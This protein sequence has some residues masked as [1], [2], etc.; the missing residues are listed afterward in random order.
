VVELVSWLCGGVMMWRCGLIRGESGVVGW[1]ACAID[2]TRSTDTHTQ[3]KTH[4]DTQNQTYTQKHTQNTDTQNHT[5]TEQHTHRATH[6]KS[7]VHLDV[8]V[9]LVALV[10][11]RGDAPR[12]LLPRADGEGVLQVEHRLV[13]VGVVGWI[14]LGWFGWVG[15][16]NEGVCD[17]WGMQT[18][19]RGAGLLALI[20]QRTCFQCVYLAKGPVEKC[21]GLCSCGVMVCSV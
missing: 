2:L 10:G 21:S 15:G 11:R 6:I 7:V 1:C 17:V 3:S 4:P 5:H 18:R 20:G 13:R 19:G 12:E 9:P 16:W 14:R 8:Q